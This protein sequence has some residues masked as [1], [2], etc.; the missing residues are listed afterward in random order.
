MV[1]SHASEL[2]FLL[3]AVNAGMAFLTDRKEGYTWKA[4]KHALTGSTNVV[5][6]TSKC[7]PKLKTRF[8]GMKTRNRSSV[9]KKIPQ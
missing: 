3:R 4:S 8:S 1:R 7:I 6:K 2:G 5:L 9:E